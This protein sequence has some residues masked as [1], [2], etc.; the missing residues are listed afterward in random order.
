MIFSSKQIQKS[1]IRPAN[2]AEDLEKL[3]LK[4]YMECSRDAPKTSRAYSLCLMLLEN[5]IRED[6]DS[7]RQVKTTNA[8]LGEHLFK[9]PAGR[10]LLESIGFFPQTGNI[11][12]NDMEVK[13]LKTYRTDLEVAFRRY[14]DSVREGKS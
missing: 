5:I 4:H 11:Y 9:F 3:I 12:R 1:A 10:Q 13:Y 7:F 6:T 14:E 2:K 8:Q